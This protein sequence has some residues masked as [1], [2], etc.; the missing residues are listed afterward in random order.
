MP[1]ATTYLT[2]HKATRILLVGDP[3]ARKTTAALHLATSSLIDRI[4]CLD[5]DDNLRGPLRQLPPEALAKIHI[6][7]LKDKVSFD[8]DGFASVAGVPT[9]FPSLVRLLA[10]WRDSDTGEAFG[11]PE[12]W[13]HRDVLLLDGC[14]GLSRAARFHTIYVNKRRG[15]RPLM[16][17]KDWGNLFER[18]SG[19][20]QAVCQG[21]PCQVVVTAHLARL[22]VDEPDRDDEDEG[23]QSGGPTYTKGGYTAPENAM[24]RYPAALGQKL[25]PQIGGDFEAIVQAKRVGKDLTAKWVLKTT[26]D[27]DVDVKLPLR[28][29]EVGGIEIPYTN[30]IDIISKSCHIE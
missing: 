4:F 17:I 1:T 23:G 12:S 2:T 30:L 7:T 9:A 29:K 5:L 28:Q 3:G 11:P 25:P 24:M 8:G 18:C 20:I 21:L 14:S 10:D 19:I 26:P 22:A 6:E 16:R 15:K 13:T 27:A